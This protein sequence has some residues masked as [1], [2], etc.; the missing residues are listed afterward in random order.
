MDDVT[1]TEVGPDSVVWDLW[2]PDSGATGSSFARG[3]LAATHRLWMHAAPSVVD[4]DVRTT[5]GA[6]IASGRQLSRTEK[7]P[8]A[9]LLQ[10]AGRVTR[11]DRW[12]GAADL[13]DPVILQGGEVGI[14]RAWWNS[15][16]RDEWRWTLEFYNHT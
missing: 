10:S 9:L 4:V 13:G 3:R 6:L 2:S 11:E 5:S 15:P 1:R 7:S 16:Q 8:M 14:L 12:P